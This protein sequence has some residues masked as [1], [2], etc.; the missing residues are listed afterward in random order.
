M[1]QR[2]Q[3]IFLLLASASFWTLFA[4]PFASSDKP[5]AQ[6]LADQSYA[7]N[8]H[9]VLLILAI[10]GGVIALG[11]IF[12]FRNR[13]LQIRMSYLS[14]I[15]SILL[16]VAVVVLFYTE[17]SEN[18]MN[19]EIDDRFG[20]YLP[21]IGIIASIFAARFIRKDEKTVRSMDRLR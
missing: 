2:I 19:V 12:L 20:I 17:A 10:L 6:F 4:F 9:I 3:S 13:P 18:S 15:L 8:D 16:P 11:A 14:L 21:I 1:L 5:T 7:I